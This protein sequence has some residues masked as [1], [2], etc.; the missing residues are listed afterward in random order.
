MSNSDG[1]ERSHYAQFDAASKEGSGRVGARAL[2][3]VGRLSARRVRALP[4]PFG[5]RLK[6]VVVAIVLVMRLA[7][8]L[9][10]AKTASARASIARA[11]IVL[12][13]EA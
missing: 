2:R 4:Q 13:A 5:P 7:A 12:L 9:L 11:S 6:D 8:W 10:P 1:D 3:S